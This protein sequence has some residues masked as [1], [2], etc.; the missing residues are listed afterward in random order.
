MEIS[1]SNRDPIIGRFPIHVAEVEGNS[2]VSSRDYL[3]PHAKE[4]GSLAPS[5][6]IL[7]SLQGSPQ[8]LMC[9]D[10]GTTHVLHVPF[11]RRCETMETQGG[12]R[13]KTQHH[14][15][16]STHPYPFL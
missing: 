1:F 7:A 5:R 10:Q 12:G 4:G 3:V 8:D 6:G 16:R 9:G 13:D 15:M 14:E 2:V 11:L